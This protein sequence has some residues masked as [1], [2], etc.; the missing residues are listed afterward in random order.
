MIGS[1]PYRRMEAKKVQR[2]EDALVLYF[3]EGQERIDPVGG[4]CVRI[5]YTGKDAFSEE[6]K[7]GVL[8]Q[9]P[10]GDWT[11]EEEGDTI[12]LQLPDLELC[13][14]RQTNRFTWYDGSGRELLRE[15]GSR[16]K[17][18]EEFPIYEMQEGSEQK[19]IVDTA[20]GRKEVIRDAARVQVGTAYHTRLHLEFGEE[21][22]FGLGQHEEGYASLRGQR[23]FLHQANRKIAVPLLVSTGGYGILV[24]TYAPAIFQDTEEGSYLYTECDPEM[25]FFFLS[26][27]KGGHPTEGVSAMD[28]VIALYRQL[29]GKAA[30]LPR[31]AFGYL[32]SQERYETQEEILRVAREYRERGI[33]LDCIVL[34]WL[35]WPDG[36]WGQK[37]FDPER[38][39]DPAEM[40]RKLHEM[41]VHFM[42]SIWPN[43]SDGTLN[44]EEMKEHRALLP[45][46]HV[47]NA[48]SEE[49]RKLYWQQV[50][51]GLFRH[52]V[53]AWWCDSS[54][55][56]TFEWNH[57]VR[58]E[59]ARMYEEYC[60][61]AARH[62]PAARTN[63]FSF[64][65]AKALYEG[66]R[67]QQEGDGLR[68]KRV[69]NLTR[70][71][72]TGQ[73]RYGAI[74]WSGDI[75]ASWETLRRQ[76]ASG[77]NFCAS[78]MPY[79]TVDIGAFFVKNGQ[80]WYW[81]G[82]YEQG[83]EDPAYCELFTR[84]YEWGAFL[85]VF[86]GHGTDVR[87]EL[88]T[89]DHP[90]APFYEALKAANRK[91]YE[92]MPY[93]YS[94]AGCAW[95]REG[96]IMKPLA[97]GFP[98]DR[99]TWQIGDQ[100]LLGDGVMVCPVT[101]PGRYE[102]APDGSES[103]V[104]DGRQVYLPGGCDW[105][106]LRTWERFA[107]GQV[108]RAQAPLESI[109]M[110]AKAGTILPMRESALSAEE[111]TGAVRL[112]I[113]GGADG[114]FL[115]YDDDGDGYGYE[116]GAYTLTEFVWNEEAKALTADGKRLEVH[117]VRE[118]VFECEMP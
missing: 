46:V 3:E 96:L 118:G 47:Y 43:V 41:H 53:D 5:R 16:S 22:L 14:N 54:E 84:W 26:A 79:W 78:G 114:R 11:F 4:G 75:S 24:N 89:F 64:Y 90:K 48:L 87:R 104:H 34:D 50:R 58:P 61:S 59:S 38:F 106:D 70:S 40:I 117:A 100:Y 116:T 42:I 92:L 97:F 62:L 85:P 88:W 74:L 25:D 8:P 112:L 69:V 113:F 20:D 36:Q 93:F 13:I 98:Q 105:Y 57:M 1:A 30:L 86:R 95:L 73:Q 49:G 21:A 83:A 7:P 17:E 18:L 37:S 94:L 19:E 6:E 115:F 33:G 55:P 45:G 52:G 12:R 91:R 56:F 68:E 82:A 107:G 108:I 2:E 15:H 28:R 109:P 101:T 81:D 31:W 76:I 29:T 35:S 32:Q 44:G 99:E 27:G 77:V 10:F 66:Q 23:I 80:P 72:Y 111:Q 67:G 65:H 63:A 110:Y 102:A 51:E 71:A 9:A 103:Y 60:Q 39:P